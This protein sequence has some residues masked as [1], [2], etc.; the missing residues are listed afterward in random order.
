LAAGITF[1]TIFA[2]VG[3]SVAAAV[4]SIAAVGAIFVDAGGIGAVADMV[5]GGDHKEHM[6]R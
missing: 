1:V 5:F 4:T 6:F 3:V 2:V